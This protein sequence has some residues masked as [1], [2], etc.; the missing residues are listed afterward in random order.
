MLS[1]DRVA[2]K[3][4]AQMFRD[5]FQNFNALKHVKKPAWVTNLRDDSPFNTVPV[6][7]HIGCLIDAGY[8][9]DNAAFRKWL[10]KNSAK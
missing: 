5:D 7:Q 2:A 8:D 6:R 9:V 10:T 1:A 3:A 4:T